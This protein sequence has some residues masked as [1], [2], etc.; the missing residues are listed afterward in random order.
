MYTKK[1]LVAAVLLALGSGLAQATPAFVS[2]GFDP[3][4]SHPSTS[5]PVSTTSS[6]YLAQQALR[7]Q[8]NG[9]SF[10]TFGFERSEGVFI[11]DGL[12]Q[13]AV[14]GAVTATITAGSGTL[15][16][17]AEEGR[18]NTT[19]G[20]SQY[21]RIQAAAGSDIA[22]S[23]RVNF[24][25]D[26]SA[27]GFYA[28]DVGDFEGTLKLV[29]RDSSDTVLDTLTV[30]DASANAALSGSLLF[31][32]FADRSVAYRSVTFLTTGS[33]DYFGFDD[34]VVGTAANLKEPTLPEP[35]SL[36]LTGLALAAAGF[37]AR[38]TRPA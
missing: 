3:T 31:F 33:N 21:L 22:S 23:F 20:G 38:R 6:S 13:D 34:F 19:T 7:G 25:A 5:Q 17:Q 32:G 26:I 29:L 8:F 36:A 28:T 14:F 24:D 11:A 30:R 2:S 4:P 10:T 16:N 12:P 1:T 9:G 18:Y 27:F 35:T 37:A 15:M